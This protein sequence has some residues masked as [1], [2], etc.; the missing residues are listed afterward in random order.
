MGSDDDIIIRGYKDR[1]N[2]YGWFTVPAWTFIA[3]PI[4]AF[5]AGFLL[6]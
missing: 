2:Y 4:V 6:G 3:A 1:V 5:I